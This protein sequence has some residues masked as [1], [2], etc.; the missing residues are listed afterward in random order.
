[1][2]SEGKP[3]IAVVS[4]AR[5]AGFFASRWIDYYSGHLGAANLFLFID[6]H[7][8]PLPAG[9]GGINILRLPHKEQVRSRGDRNRARL[10]SYFARSLFHRYDLIIAHDIDEFLVIDP[11]ISQSFHEYFSRPVRTASL[12][13]LGLDVGQH[14]GEEE[15]LDHER[16]FLEQRRYAHVSA[17]YTKAVVAARPL[18][19]GSG[20]HR[21]KGRNF[22]IDPALYLFHFGMVDYD[23]CMEKSGG[24]SLPGPGWQGHLERRYEL[25]D[26]ISRADAI[27]GDEFFEKARRRQSLF[28]PIYALNKP[29]MLKEKPVIRIPERF[30]TLV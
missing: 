25:F 12:S 4:M 10:I 9:S 5:D 26:I 22:H 11:A 6:G 27:D 1:M 28:R 20:F 17:R 21:V 3:K 8:Q 15:A 13:A 30:R 29:G 23:S 16:P 24:G 19:W 7:D 14:P 18:T 2:I